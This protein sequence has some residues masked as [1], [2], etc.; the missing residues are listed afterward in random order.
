MIP[1]SPA[2][3]TPPLPGSTRSWD[4]AGRAMV[5][6]L[7]ACLPKDDGS[8]VCGG[9]SVACS[10]CMKNT[11]RLFALVLLGLAGGC[12]GDEG[13]ECPSAGQRPGESC[14]DCPCG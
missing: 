1:G 7:G 8:Q 3:P 2:P 9:T 12:G 6:S 11:L 13:A 10:G 4:R 5:A 14:V